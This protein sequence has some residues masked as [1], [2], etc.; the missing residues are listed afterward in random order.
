M[1]KFKNGKG[2]FNEDLPIKKIRIN[3]NDMVGMKL[4]GEYKEFEFKNLKIIEY[5]PRKPQPQFKVLYNKAEFLIDCKNLLSGNIG[6]ILN[7]FIDINNKYIDDNDVVHIFITTKKGYKFEALYSGNHV[8]EVMNANWQ[9]KVNKNGNILSISSSNYNGKKIMLHQVDLGNWVDHKD[10]NPLNNKIE[11][12]RKTNPK[13]NA[14]NRRSNGCC[15]IT[16]L[17]KRRGLYYCQYSDCESGFKIYTQLKRDID[18]VKIDGLIAQRYLG[19]KHNEDMFYLLDE[20]PKKRI[21]E[22]EKLLNEKIKIIRSKTHKEREYY[23]NVR[24]Y[25]GYYKLKKNGKEMLF[26]CDLNFIKNKSIDESNGYWACVFVEDG[27]KIKNRF[28]KEIL[29]VRANEY[30]EYD[31]HIDHLNGNSND[32]RFC[33]LVITTNYSNQCNK[34]SKGYYYSKCGSYQVAYM[35]NYKFWELIGGSTQPTYKTEQEA[36]K[37]VNRRRKIVDNARVKLKSREE[38]DKLIQYCLDNGYILQNGL[39]DLDLGYLYWKGIL[40]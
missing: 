37:E 22:V 16:G 24:K 6:A 28:H 1:Y 39:A 17:S 18:E 26:D 29:N 33:N 31:I 21:E 40:K 14:K 30:Q 25:D 3:R 27:K 38:L 4:S 10:N 5:I 32:N 36:I 35:K 23:H 11:N 34:N 7:I 2:F 19:Y 8:K 13:D 9:A 12:L 20:L 15:E